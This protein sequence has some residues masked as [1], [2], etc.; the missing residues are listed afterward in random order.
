[1]AFRENAVPKFLINENGIIQKNTLYRGEVYCATVQSS[2][3]DIEQFV[4]S[5]NRLTV[6]TGQ[7]FTEPSKIVFNFNYDPTM[8]YQPSNS[9]EP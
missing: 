5:Y 3:C 7:N 1:M 8:E 2:D 9:C 4:I 6:N